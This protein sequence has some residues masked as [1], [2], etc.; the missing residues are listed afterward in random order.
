MDVVDK[1]DWCSISQKTLVGSSR[2]GVSLMVLKNVGFLE[3][4]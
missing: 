3:E 1:L 4:R 2:K